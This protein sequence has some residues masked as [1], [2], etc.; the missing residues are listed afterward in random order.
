MDFITITIL[1]KTHDITSE[2]NPILTNL[3]ARLKIKYSIKLED[4]HKEIKK[5]IFSNHSYFQPPN[6]SHKQSI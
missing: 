3:L 1:M 5:K 2:V 4:N 6:K